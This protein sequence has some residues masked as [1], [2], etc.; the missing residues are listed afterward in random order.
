MKSF[1]LLAAIIFL[2]LHLVAQPGV[3]CANPVIIGTL[4]YSA[5]GLTTAG[6]GNDYNSSQTC[7]STYMS[8]NDFVFRYQA[9]SSMN[10]RVALSGTGPFAGVFVTD[11]CPDVPTANCI[12]EA[13]ST[14]GNPVIE[15]APLVAGTTYYIIVSTY[16]VSGL[17]PS[18][19]FNIEIRQV[20]QYDASA[21]MVFQPRTHCDMTADEAVILQIQNAGTET[22]NS[23][24]VGYSVNGQPEVIE[25]CNITIAPGTVTYHHFT[26]LPDLTVAG[27]YE[28]TMFTA[29]AGEEN[30]LNDTVR[31]PVWNNSFAPSF[32][33]HEDF[34]SGDG[35]WR[36]QWIS[37]TSP[38]SSWE[39]GVP[40]ATVINQ[41]A[42]GTQC[43]ATNL[44][45][46]TLSPERSFLISPCFDFSGMVNPVFE[47]DIWYETGSTDLIYVE[48]SIDSTYDYRF[49]NLLGTYNS[50][51]NWYNV[52][53]TAGKTGWSGNSGGWIHVRQSCDGLG[54]E[55]CVIFRVVFEGSYQTQSEGVAVDNMQISENPLN[56]LS[57]T[58]IISP[59]PSCGLSANTDVTV[60]VANLGLNTQPNPELR[61]SINNGIS[62]ESENL[63]LTLNYQDTVTFTFTQKADLSNPGLYG[64]IV[65]TVL[66]GDQFPNNDSAYKQ[67]MSYPDI[68]PPYL[69]DFES[70]NGFWLGEGLNS[71]WA[72]G[73]PAE[74]TINQ[75]ASGTQ[76][77]VTNLTGMHSV[78]EAS[79]LTGPCIDLT[80]MLNPHLKMNIWY[81]YTGPGYCQVQY[82]D[83][84]GIN[85]AALGS[86]NDPDWYTAGYSWSGSSGNWRAVKHHLSGLPLG[87]QLRLNMQ[88]P[89]AS[90][91]FAFDDFEICDGPKASFEQVFLTKAPE[92]CVENLSLNYDSV[93]WFTSSGQHSTEN[94]VVCF[95]GYAS[96]AIT[97]TV[98][99]VAYNSCTT[100]TFTLI[101]SPVNDIEAYDLNRIQVYPNPFA[102]Q[103]AITAQSELAGWEISD[104]AGRTIMSGKTN[105]STTLI[106]TGKLSKGSYLLRIY[107]KNGHVV[108]RPVIKK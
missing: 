4:P 32:P 77:W 68:T 42:S 17:F 47:M 37:H 39:H 84:G 60:K 15:S 35:N 12:A 14:G 22:I 54:G 88:S 29:L 108:N 28:F 97:D 93:Y 100:D 63:A 27:L 25:T 58:S 46:N 101:L 10:V 52:P 104:I 21:Q 80:G 82:L 5:S 3:N 66:A 1:L 64:V 102:D 8:G 34:E 71:T 62:W 67:V 94:T 78:P 26:Q 96:E 79:T 70:N 18:T 91:G 65:K 6:F 92:I 50:G 76:A 83:A 55:P 95:T 33:Y 98:T 61:Y 99:L 103:I 86:A 2:S 81:E 74:A 44:S 90:P 31:F 69:N 107:G 49:Y 75:A 48:Y 23:V 87:V 59:L 16:N 24:Q 51:L 45:G 57:V 11:N 43:W 36:S 56:D 41:A 40:S 106:P 85:W 53:I 20:Y 19:A 9:A 30:T 38:G 13:E 72:F 73:T 105:D 89:L 7:N